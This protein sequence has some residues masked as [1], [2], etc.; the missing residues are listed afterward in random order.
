MAIQKLDNK[1]L[2]KYNGGYLWMLAPIGVEAYRHAD[3]I[4]KGAAKGAAKAR[5]D[6]GYK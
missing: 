2:K 5:Q 6:A 3:E 4:G 1:E